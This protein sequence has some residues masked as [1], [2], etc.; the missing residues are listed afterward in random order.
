MSK[1]DSYERFLELDAGR[2]LG[3]LSSEEIVEWQEL[4]TIHQEEDPIGFDFLVAEL[5][6]RNVPSTSVPSNLTSLLSETIHD[7]AKPVEKEPASDTKVVSIFPWLGWAAAACLFI[8]FN[9]FD[10]SEEPVKELTAS[11][12]LELLLQESPENTQTLPFSAA[13]DPYNTVQG[14]LIWNDDRQEGY[15]KLANLPINDPSMNQYQLWIVDPT[16]DELPVD[17]GVFDISSESGFSVISI[18]NTLPVSK[19]V[20]FLITL[21]QPGGVVRSKQEIKVALAAPT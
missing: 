14:E 4:A 15:M 17:G 12:K 3:D 16:R 13:S 6:V 7:F 9:P 8:I 11:Q 19:P 20:A 18:R 5:E 21:E 1:S 10:R 2:A